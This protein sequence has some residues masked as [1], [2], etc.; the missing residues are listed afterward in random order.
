M[1]W[2]C[3]KIYLHQIFTTS[4]AKWEKKSYG[5]NFVWSLGPTKKEDWFM[6]DRKDGQS[7]NCKLF[8]LNNAEKSWAM[9]VCFLTCIKIKALRFLLLKFW[10][11]MFDLGNFFYSFIR[12]N[13]TTNQLFSSFQCRNFS[14]LFGLTFFMCPKEN[15]A[16]FSVHKMLQLTNKM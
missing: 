13:K 10:L 6:E 5:W 9:T 11:E 4:I 1:K 15:F 12:E 3:E 16:M 8:F 7:D 2:Y 14:F